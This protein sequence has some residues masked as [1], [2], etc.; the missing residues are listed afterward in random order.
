[1]NTLR[2]DSVVQYGVENIGII[3]RMLEDAQ[4]REGYC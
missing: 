2:E 4:S 1:M 3:V